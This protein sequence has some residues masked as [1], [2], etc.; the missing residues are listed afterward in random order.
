MFEILS[1]Y[2][3]AL[4]LTAMQEWC[5][6]VLYGEKMWKNEGTIPVTTVIHSLSTQV[7]WQLRSMPHTSSSFSGQ[8]HLQSVKLLL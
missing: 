3:C 2:D 1:G 4:C 6:M 7:V 5:L 8:L